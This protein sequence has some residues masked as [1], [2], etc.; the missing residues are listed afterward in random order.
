VYDEFHLKILIHVDENDLPLSQGVFKLQVAKIMNDGGCSD[1]V[2]Y[3]DVDDA[4]S[5]IIFNTI[6]ETDGSAAKT[7][8]EDPY[9]VGEPNR[10]QSYEE[11]NNFINS[12][13]EI[14]PG[15]NGLWDFSLVAV[16]LR[17]YCFQIVK[18]DDSALP[19]DVGLNY[20][21]VIVE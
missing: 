9:N 6:F 2:V 15:E 11:A 16:D 10:Y 4:G 12:E 7:T 21:K 5:G 3:N 14:L 19:L 13:S 8:E 20:P 18:D 1:G 17:S